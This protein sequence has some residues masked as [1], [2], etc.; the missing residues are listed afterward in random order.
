MLPFAHV[1]R[2]GRVI[3]SWGEISAVTCV[4]AHAIMFCSTG[5]QLPQALADA[6]FFVESIRKRYGCMSGP[7][8]CP[9]ITVGGSYPGWLSGMMRLRYPGVVDMAYAASAPMRFYSQQVDQ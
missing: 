3:A 2:N 5:N 8:R 4:R 6:A 7:R 1:G 9:V